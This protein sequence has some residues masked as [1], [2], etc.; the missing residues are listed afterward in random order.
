MIKIP[1]PRSCRGKTVLHGS[2]PA[3][4]EV[5]IMKIIAVIRLLQRDR[6]ELYSAGYLPGEHLN[7]V[8]SQGVRD[9]PVQGQT[10]Q[11]RDLKRSSQHCCQL[12]AITPYSRVLQHCSP[13]DSNRWNCS[14]HQAEDFCTSTVT[15][16]STMHS[17][18]I[19]SY[20]PNNITAVIPVEY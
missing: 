11:C 17:I 2:S 4:D 5:N 1:I 16:H 12:N 14:W 9:L 18:A 13:L 15:R 10:C 8:C 3:A 6:Y 7:S 19:Y 20:S